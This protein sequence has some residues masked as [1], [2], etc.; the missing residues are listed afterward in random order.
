MDVWMYEACEGVLNQGLLAYTY[1]DLHILDARRDLGRRGRY[2]KDHCYSTVQLGDL[3]LY[4]CE[5]PTDH[6]R[7]LRRHHCTDRKQSVPSNTQS[8]R[9]SSHYNHFDQKQ[10]YNMSLIE[11]ARLISA[12]FALP[13]CSWPTRAIPPT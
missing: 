12:F 5:L 6:A 2:T 11:V 7:P 8:T 9:T 1:I 10:R 4:D 13:R 3:F